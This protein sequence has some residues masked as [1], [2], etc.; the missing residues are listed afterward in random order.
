MLKG[1]LRGAPIATSLVMLLVIFCSSANAGEGRRI[2]TGTLGKMP[3]VMEVQ[4]A[5]PTNISGRYFY[6]K[7]RKDIAL[8]GVMQGATLVLNEGEQPYG[9]EKPL[10][11]I[12]LNIE[13]G[14]AWGEWSND[15]GKTLKIELTEAELPAISAGTLPYLAK[16]YDAEPYEYLRLQGMNLKQGKTQTFQGYSLQWWSEPQTKTAFFEIV[17]GYTPEV[18]DRINKLLLG[19]LWQEVVEYYGCFSAGGGAYYLQTVKPLLITPKV[20]SISVGTE[21]YCG[22]AHPDY[23]D[24]YINIDAQNGKPVT[25]EDVLWVG[26]GKPLH[27]EERNSEQSAEVSAAY[28]EYRNN[29]F[30]PWLVAQLRQLYPEE[31]QPVPDDNCTYGEQ[32][33]WDYPTWYFAE[34]GIKFGP[35]FSHADAPCAF[36]DWSVLPYSVIKQNPGG[37]AAQLP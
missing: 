18:R 2:F 36:V 7:Y 1:L 25:L 30:A 11:Q 4:T 23:S 13:T 32:D 10:P 17:S 3:I 6:Q 35:S 9:D 22:G 37:V 14:K 33:H 21:A 15:Q 27:Y 31:M 26:Q 29:E 5:A 8:S 16:L 19:R 12:H 24:A 20:I 28:S 34:N